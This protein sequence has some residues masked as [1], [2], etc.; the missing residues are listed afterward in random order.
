MS[1]KNYSEAESL[2][3]AFCVA[4]DK[5]TSVTKINVELIR[6]KAQIDN[7]CDKVSDGFNATPIII[8][9]SV[10]GT[11]L[12]GG[13]VALAIILINNKKKKQLAQEEKEAE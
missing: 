10:G 9:A 12:I 5:S 11:L 4:V 8:A 1:K 2:Y 7:L 6:I 13:G 3:N